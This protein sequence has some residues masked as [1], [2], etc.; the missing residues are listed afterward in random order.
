MMKY[1]Q[2]LKQAIAFGLEPQGPWADLTLTQPCLSGQGGGAWVMLATRAES[3]L[4][5]LFWDLLGHYKCPWPSWQTLI[6]PQ[7]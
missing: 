2:T 5:W 6:G 7:L 4:G 3:A 1:N